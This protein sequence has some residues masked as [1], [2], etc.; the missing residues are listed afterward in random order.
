MKKRLLSILM[1]ASMCLSLSACGGKD[2][3][4]PANDVTDESNE[5]SFSYNISALLSKD[6]SM[7]EILLKGFSDALSDYIG[8]DHF[9]ITTSYASE[10]TPSDTIASE[11]VKNSSDM[12]FTTGKSTLVAA[13]DATET[14]PIIATDIVDFKGTLRIASLGGKSWDKTTGR[15][16][17]GV[18][19]KPSIVDQVSLMIESTKDLQTVGI[20]F[21]PEDTDAIYQN[22][23]F[24]AYLDQAGIPWKEYLIPATSTKLSDDKEKDS[25]AL[26]PSKYVAFSAKDGM[27]NDVISLGDNPLFGLNSPSSTRVALVSDFWTGPKVVA[28]PTPAEEADEDSKTDSDEKSDS[29]KSDANDIE[30]EISLEDRITEACS[31]CSAI[32]VPFESMLTDQ[33]DVIGSVAQEQDVVVVAGDTNIGQ[34]SLVTLFMDPYS[35]GYAAGKKAVRVFNGDDI[36]TIKIGYGDTDECVKLYN[37]EIAEKFD[38]TFPKSFSEFTEFLSSYTYGSN[39]TRFSF[40]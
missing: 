26:T 22:E 18:S 27:D 23:I 33:M 37:G 19:S 14:I 17:T 39:T 15:N 2:K 11:A 21:S 24:E 30:S 40:N 13:A 8:D 5:D 29:G 36:T 35:L 25:T 9:T 10:E 28:K 32:Y 31:E 20:L 3:S 4:E 34:N 16:I 1:I 38:M 6:N 12:I 7:D